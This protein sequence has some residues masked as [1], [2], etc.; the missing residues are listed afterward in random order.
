MI[1]DY[2]PY[3]I[4]VRREQWDRLGLGEVRGA[5]AT[6]GGAVPGIVF[7]RYAAARLNRQPDRRER[8]VQAREL[9]LYVLLT[10]IFRHVVARYAAEQAPD[11][12]ARAA[13]EA[14][15]GLEEG[16]LAETLAGLA[17]LF[18]PAPVLDGRETPQRFLEEDAEGRRRRTALA[19][20]LLLRVTSENPAVDDF[21]VL[22]DDRSLT[23]RTPYA[24]VAARVEDSL[25][26]L[27][28]V[29]PFGLALPDLLRAPIRAAPASLAS[30]LEYVRENWLAVLPDE[31]L[32]DV[33]TAFDLYREEER[34]WWGTAGPPQV[35]EFGEGARRRGA[36]ARFDYPEPEAFSADADWMS[37]VV[38]VAKMTYVWLDQLSKRHGREI[39]RLDQI[40][41]EELDRLARWGFTGLWLIGLWERSP[42]SQKIK[43]IAGNP[44]AI[45][46]AYSLYDYAPAAD[47]GGEEALA[48]LRERAM[49]RGIRLASDMVPNHCGLWS[50]WLR[51]HPDWFIQADWPPYPNY[52]FGG[53]DLSYDPSVSIRIEDGYWERRDAAVVFQHADHRTGRVRYVYHGNDGTSTPWNDTAQLDYL[54]PEVREAVI[55]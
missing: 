37:N 3:G 11:A 42:A 6:R 43:Q 20:A 55:R 23:E 39:R 7:L 50:R 32:R 1:D 22:V 17:E 34:E 21:R 13:S 5:L 9:N 4:Q 51:E 29:A 30:Q 2:F 8:P 38:L 46:S 10:R 40:P 36:G 27:P 15:L 48:S 45:S 44:D 18:P 49:R 28:P 53:P 41:D 47:L 35:L 14:G 26:K 19:E 52:T 54:R 24:A 16:A 31:L 33:L 12:L 25:R